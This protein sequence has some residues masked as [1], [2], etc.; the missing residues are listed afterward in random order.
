MADTIFSQLRQNLFTATKT[1][2]P[3]NKVVF[4][5]TNIEEPDE[6]YVIIRVIR[7]TKIGTAKT[8]TLLNSSG[9][10]TTTT[11]HEAL[12]QFSFISADEI[13]DANPYDTAGDMV[14]FFEQ[15]LETSL[16]REFF[17]VNNLAKMRVSPVRN[18]AYQRETTWANFYN[19]DVTF[20]YAIRTEQNM[21]GIDTVVVEEPN[22]DTYTIPPNVIIP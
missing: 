16:T 17:R 4:G 14:T 21:V 9:V 12:V 15:S 6:P 8:D 2:F 19:I 11:N 22:G 3:D 13:T 5:N 18:V 1:L 20:L 10:M 7:D